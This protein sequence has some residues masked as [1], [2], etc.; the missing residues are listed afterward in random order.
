MTKET[1]QSIDELYDS[2]GSEVDKKHEDDF[3]NDLEYE[4]ED[5][6]L[7]EET[8]S[9]FTQPERKPEWPYFVI[10]VIILLLFVLAALVAGFVVFL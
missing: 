8:L 1:D 6:D 4:N 9:H 3:E 7:E 10:G 5:E 2:A